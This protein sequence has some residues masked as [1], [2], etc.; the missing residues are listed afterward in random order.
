LPV[1]HPL[2][3]AL[4]SDLYRECGLSLY[5]IKLVTGQPA[6]AAGALLRARGAA[7]RPPGGRSPFMRRWRE[8]R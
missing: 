4:V 1:P 3:A 7:L 8:G 5:H 2:T 6:A